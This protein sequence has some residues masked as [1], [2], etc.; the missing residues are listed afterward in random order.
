MLQVLYCSITPLLNISLLCSMFQQQLTLDLMGVTENALLHF[1]NKMTEDSCFAKCRENNEISMCRLICTKKK[2]LAFFTGDL[3][4]AAKFYDL[5]QA[6]F[7]GGS[8]GESTMN[9][10]VTISLLQL[11]RGRKNN[12]TIRFRRPP[13]ECH[14]KRF[15][16]WTDW[17]LFGEKASR[18]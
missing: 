15:Y 13:C 9:I 1:A 2:Y 18:R 17:L 7:S 4:T 12:I 3:D 14:S 5:H 8:T 10:F 11:H 6:H 16:R